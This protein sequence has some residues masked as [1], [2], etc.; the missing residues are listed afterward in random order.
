M[1][2]TASTIFGKV[3]ISRLSSCANYWYSNS[4]HY[5]IWG[6]DC[7]HGYCV[8]YD[9]A[10]DKDEFINFVK[11]QPDSTNTNRF[12]TEQFIENNILYIYCRRF[13]HTNLKILD[14]TTNQWKKQ[15]KQKF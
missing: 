2:A 13:G 15:K 6:M 7:D 11:Y 12:S 9:L 5:M 10:S 4:K 1:P 14:L 3:E 8:K